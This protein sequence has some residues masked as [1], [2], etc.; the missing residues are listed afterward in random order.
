MTDSHSV[1]NT[2]LL[3]DVGVTE[4]SVQC[5]RVRGQIIFK[6]HLMITIDL[7]ITYPAHRD[8]KA[9]RGKIN[10]GQQFQSSQYQLSIIVLLL[11][12]SILYEA[13]NLCNNLVF[14]P[15]PRILFYCYVFN[16]ACI[17]LWST[18]NLNFVP[19][20]LSFSLLAHPRILEAVFEWLVMEIFSFH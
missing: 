20:S 11:C 1:W 17:L 7:S 18:Q 12:V 16:Y 10:G 9:S 14:G 6:R 19:K 5:V 2:E 8:I 15:H 13:E 3:A 4:L